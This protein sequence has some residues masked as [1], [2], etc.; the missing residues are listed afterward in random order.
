MRSER[1]NRLRTVTLGN[2][3]CADINSA[4]KSNFLTVGFEARSS[5]ITAGT[6]C[7]HSSV[8]SKHSLRKLRT[9]H[10]ISRANANGDQLQRLPLAPSALHCPG[11]QWS[12][13]SCSEAETKPK[14]LAKLLIS[15]PTLSGILVLM[16]LRKPKQN[17]PRR[18]C[19]L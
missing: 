4:R 18:H 6:A 14:V 19:G 3:F 11:V 9:L 2:Q 17:R 8:W 7:G 15:Q 5:S 1:K 16:H 13:G 10:C 12:S